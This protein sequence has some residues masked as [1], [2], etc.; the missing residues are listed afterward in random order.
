MN[1]FRL[2][3]LCGILACGSVAAA[4]MAAVDGGSYRP[5]YLKKETPLIRVKPYRI[6]KYPVTNADFAAFVKKHPQW[7][8]GKVSSKQAEDGYL[9][10]WVKSGNGF[11]PKQSEA[12]HPVTNVSWFAAHAYCAAQGKRLPT[13]DEWEFAGQASAT[14][15]NGTAE[16]GYNRTILDWYADG[17]RNGLRNIGQ[18]PANYW[19][20]YDM[21]GLIWEWTEDFNSSLLAA[22]SS[23]QMFCS[24]ASAGS[25]DPS[26]YAAFLRFGIRTSLQ[27][28]YTLNNLGFR[29]AVSDK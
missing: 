13:I 29:C 17:G 24:G 10:H 15:K 1:T 19:G 11:A 20:I 7:Q 16:A 5:L 23:T 6:D 22:G 26:N 18:S 21:H 3:A 8:R 2:F 28:K 27:A 25:S 12:R 4:D 9:K 14:Q